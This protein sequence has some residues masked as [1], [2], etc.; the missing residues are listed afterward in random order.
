MIIS[1]TQAS[2][3]SLHPVIHTHTGKMHENFLHTHTWDKCRKISCTQ[4][5][6][7]QLFTHMGQMQENFLHASQYILP[8]PSCSHT[9]MGQ[10]QENF[11]YTSQ[12]ILPTPSYSHTWDKCAK[13][14]CTQVSIIYFIHTNITRARTYYMGTSAGMFLHVSQVYIMCKGS[15]SGLVGKGS[16]SSWTHNV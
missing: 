12:Y 8:T 1:L 16:P 5:N 14:P 11:P 2:T 15:S 9:H 7:T 13:I 6:Y 10:M 4:A 3:Y